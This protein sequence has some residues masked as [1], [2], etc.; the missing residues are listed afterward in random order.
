ML[1]TIHPAEAAAELLRRDECRQ[2]LEAFCEDIH[3]DWT[4]GD[5]LTV[6]IDHLMRLEAGELRY[7][8]VFAPPRH[9]KT[10][11]VGRQFPAWYLGRHPRRQVIY[12][13]HSGQI[14]EDVGAD[15]RDAIDSDD[16]R[17]VFP[18]V[19]LHRNAK[20]ASRFKLQE[21][22]D[23]TGEWSNAG[24]MTSVGVGKKIPGR[25]AHLAICDDL[26]GGRNDADSRRKRDIVHSWFAGDL[27]QRVMRPKSL[28]LMF[29]RWGTDDLAGRVL[30]PPKAWIQI[31]DRGWVWEAGKWTVLLFRAIQNECPAAQHAAKGH[32]CQETALWQG[33]P[34][35][36]G[37]V[38][39][40]SGDRETLTGY[41]LEDLQ[42]MRGDLVSQGR[43]RDWQAQYQQN[44]TVEEG[45]FIQKL[46]FARR[47]RIMPDPVRTYIVWDGAL[48]DNSGDKD[49][50]RTEI[51]VF[52]IDAGDDLYVIDW[53]GGHATMDVWVDW[54]VELIAKWHPFGVIGETGM[55]RRAAQGYIRREMKQR[56]A[57]ARLVWVKHV[58]DKITRARSF[59]AM[60]SAG[61]IILPHEDASPDF[62]WIPELIEEVTAVPAGRYWDKFDVFA[63]MCQ[64]IDQ[65]HKAIIRPERA[66]RRREDY[67]G[68]KES[69]GGSWRTGGVA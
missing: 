69:G 47:W 2:N 63:M 20:A 50:D 52:G 39:G 15:V 38:D 16:Y 3:H 48:G 21:R 65:R 37:S 36:P 46:W 13:T 49:P 68:R 19:R 10:E 24:I 51:G 41:P 6:I 11:V 45:L 12:A 27:I 34:N 29:T 53:K 64:C 30:P 1:A 62:F 43:I 40:Q 44:P 33:D 5:H 56:K 31:D 22:S 23:G 17:R 59:Q 28:L 26:H 42:E 7:L 25:G 57:R 54:L 14:A 66:E 67:R 35:D 61:E 60:A 32:K 8:A 4:R 55:I 58:D 18:D 9:G